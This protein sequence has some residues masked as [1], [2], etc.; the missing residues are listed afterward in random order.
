MGANVNLTAFKISLKFKKLTIFIELR[1]D[2]T[3]YETLHTN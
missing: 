2:S 1:Q 3:I